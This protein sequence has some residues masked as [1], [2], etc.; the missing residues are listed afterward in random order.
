MSAP[1]AG[2]RPSR[3]KPCRSRRRPDQGHHA[4]ARDDVADPAGIEE[5]AVELV[6]A[7]LQDGGL[8]ARER[9]VQR[10]V[11]RDRAGREAVEAER[12]VAPRLMARPREDLGDVGLRAGAERVELPVAV[13]GPADLDEQVVVGRPGVDGST[14]APVGAELDDHGPRRQRSL[15]GDRGLQG[16]T[17]GRREPRALGDRRGLRHRPA[18]RDDSARD[19][20]G[21]ED[22]SH[23]ATV[24]AANGR[25]AGRNEPSGRPDP[26]ARC[27][28]SSGRARRRIASP[29]AGGT[30]ARR[31]PRWRGRSSTR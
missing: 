14:V 15:A 12:A 2:S 30:A 9:Q 26:R 1:V 13:A 16:H 3:S 5:V 23:A 31:H 8:H 19:C 4:R 7:G 21:A 6:G 29:A 28:G 11:D 20:S 17:V 22:R 18:Q 25:F 24:T 27:A 10:V